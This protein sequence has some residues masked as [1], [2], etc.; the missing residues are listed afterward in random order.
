MVSC[1]HSRV[2]RCTSLCV[3]FGAGLL[4]SHRDEFLPFLHLGSQ[5][6]SVMPLNISQDWVTSPTAE[7]IGSSVLSLDTPTA[8]VPSLDDEPVEHPVLFIAEDMVTLQV[9]VPLR[10]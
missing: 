6:A 10:L 5:T 9:R 2:S 7:S 1:H 3:H 8:S 4:T